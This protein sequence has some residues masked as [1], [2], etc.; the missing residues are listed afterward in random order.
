[1]R[2]ARKAPKLYSQ[3]KGSAITNLKTSG[4]ASST[5]GS[6]S[7]PVAQG[8]DSVLSFPGTPCNEFNKRQSRVLQV[9]KALW[10]QFSLRT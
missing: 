10:I 4:L 8:C 7:R 2:R 3:M 5:S 6:M 1:M 9:K